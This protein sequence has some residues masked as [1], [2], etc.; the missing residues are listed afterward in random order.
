[1]FLYFSLKKWQS[2]KMSKKGED[3]RFSIKMAEGVGKKGG[4]SKN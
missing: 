4:F 2:E 1:M 3:V